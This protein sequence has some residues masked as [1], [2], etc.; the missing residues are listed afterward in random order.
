MKL[1]GTLVKS[2]LTVAAA[3][4]ALYIRRLMK[5]MKKNNAGKESGNKTTGEPAIKRH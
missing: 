4:V 2:G 1:P 5:R 3:G